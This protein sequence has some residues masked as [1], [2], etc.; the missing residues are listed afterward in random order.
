MNVLDKLQE[1]W[2]A[3]RKRSASGRL[4]PRDSSTKAEAMHGRLL[5]SFSEEQIVN[6]VTEFLSRMIELAGADKVPSREDRLRCAACLELVS[7]PRG[8]RIPVRPVQDMV[9]TFP[10]TIWALEVA[11]LITTYLNREELLEALIAG[12][13]AEDRPEMVQNSL[14]AVKF[15]ARF[16]RRDGSSERLRSLVSQIAP[17]VAKYACDRDVK[18]ARSAARGEKALEEYFA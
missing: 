7:G 1:L 5:E 16:A 2:S 12:L 18:V 11:R 9:R 17:I 14:R 6:E 13:T 15:Y 8:I 4:L 3:P 10:I